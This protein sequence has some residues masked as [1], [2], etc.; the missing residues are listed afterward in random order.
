MPGMYVYSQ[1]A[2]FFSLSNSRKQTNDPKGYASMG[3]FDCV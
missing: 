2:I 3:I 1:T